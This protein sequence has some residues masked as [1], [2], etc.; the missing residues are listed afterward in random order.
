MKLITGLSQGI[1]ITGLNVKTSSSSSTKLKKIYLKTAIPQEYQEVE[2]IY[3]DA[4]AEPYIDTGVIYDSGCTVEWKF[5]YYA[6][7]Y[8]WG[9]FQSDS[10]RF[11]HTQ[12][13]SAS[14][15]DGTRTVNVGINAS[16]N[17]VY[18][19]QS[20]VGNTYHLIYTCGGTTTGVAEPST[21][22]VDKYTSISASQIAWKADETIPIMGYRY[23]GIMQTTAKYKLYFWNY[24]DKDGNLVRDLVPCYRKSDNVAGM[25]DK[26]TNTFY[27]NAGTTGAFTVGP[28]VYGTSYVTLY[29]LEGS[30]I[31]VNQIP[32]STNADGTIFNT[33]GYYDEHRISSS[34]NVSTNDKPQYQSTCTGFI[35]VLPGDTVILKNVYISGDSASYNTVFY[36]ASFAYVNGMTPYMFYNNVQSSMIVFAPYDYDTTTHTLYSFTVPVKPTIRYMRLSLTGHGA[37]AV[38]YVKHN[39]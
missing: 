22:Y 32:I 25:F 11:R 39:S 30:D 4:G 3:K 9:F 26:V 13:A 7:S 12:S 29:L 31:P 16:G 27:S 37:N 15:T 34:G 2:W 19:P 36:N 33:T 8:Q 35:P 14:T 24:R 20:I 1:N 38:A 5:E 28:N 23:K 10:K 18:T 17:Y 21:G 6:P